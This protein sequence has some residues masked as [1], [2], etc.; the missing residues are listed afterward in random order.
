MTLTTTAV[1]VEIAAELSQKALD[2]I[3]ELL[4]E[5]G[6]YTLE[7]ILGFLETYNSDEFLAYY[8]DF[9]E[10]V[11][12]VGYGVVDAFLDGNSICDITRV[13]DIYYGFYESE[14][15]FAENYYSDDHNI[16]P[17]MVIDW[18]ETFHQSLS[19]DFN[20]VDGYVFFRNW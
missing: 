2:H 16:P 9:E 4:E 11:K 5:D 10:Q 7:N 8:E 14:A 15:D 20:Y 19:N 1:P 17:E 3:T 6:K 13:E 18:E 12:I